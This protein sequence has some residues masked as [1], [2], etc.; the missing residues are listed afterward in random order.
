MYKD[1]LL[2][3]KL[4]NSEDFENHTVYILFTTV[5]KWD[6]TSDVSLDKS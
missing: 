6:C 3:H 5:C 2:A 1:V 4:L